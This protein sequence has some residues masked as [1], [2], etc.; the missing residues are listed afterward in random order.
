M[1]STSTPADSSFDPFWARVN[2]AGITVVVHAGDSGYTTH[3]Y[4]NDGFSSSFDGPG[5]P[6]V[7][8]FNIERAA[9]D[10]LM[11]AVF[12]KIFVRFPNL[13]VASVENGADFLGPMFRKLEQAANKSFAWFDE[14]PVET[15]RRHVWINPFWEDDVL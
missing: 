8:M 5:K 11:Q 15:F 6:S 14:D 4:T 7:K 2:E 13:R 1:A 9:Q 12:E 3:G 10:W